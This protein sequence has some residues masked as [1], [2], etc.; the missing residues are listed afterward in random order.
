METDFILRNM[1]Y[2]NSVNTRS[3]DPETFWVNCFFLLKFV[4]F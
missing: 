2:V 1:N 4:R 3:L